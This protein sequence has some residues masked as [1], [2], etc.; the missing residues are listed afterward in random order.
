MTGYDQSVTTSFT[1]Q[2]THCVMLPRQLPRFSFSQLFSGFFD[3]FNRLVEQSFD[4]A[5]QRILQST[6]R[7]SEK[8]KG[9]NLISQTEFCV[10]HI[11]L[12]V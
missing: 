11:A 7:F 10:D 8:L 12:G 4:C 6:A 9:P 2:L 3:S 1:R 5:L